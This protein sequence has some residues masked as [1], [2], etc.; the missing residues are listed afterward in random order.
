MS[1]REI[2][3]RFEGVDKRVDRMVPIDMWNQ[4]NKHIWEK[5]GEIDER[6]QNTWVRALG[7]FGVVATLVAAVVAA[8]LAAY[9]S[10]RGA[11]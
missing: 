9:L 11:H 6:G 10:A 3:R 1:D 5:F 7:I 2:E 8:V 4:E